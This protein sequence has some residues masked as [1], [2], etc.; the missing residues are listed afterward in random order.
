MDNG[1]EM[2]KNFCHTIKR[3]KVE[4]ILDKFNK[5]LLDEL[6]SGNIVSFKKTLI[7]AEIIR[8]SYG[9]QYLLQLRVD[10]EYVTDGVFKVFLNKDIRSKLKDKKNKFRYVNK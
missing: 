3:E 4:S 7:E 9:V 10:N 1:Y 5:V 2:T 6:E 8:T